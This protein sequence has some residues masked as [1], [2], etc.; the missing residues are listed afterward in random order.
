MIDLFTFIFSIVYSLFYTHFETGDIVKISFALSSVG[1]Q[2]R[3]IDKFD[4]LD[5]LKIDT[6]KHTIQGF[7]VDIMCFNPSA[8]IRQDH[9]ISMKNNNL[10]LFID[11]NDTSSTIANSIVSIQL[12]GFR[13]YKSECV[14][15]N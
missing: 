4:T 5:T 12:G 13:L 7:V 8:F 6:L 15:K 3:F 10:W 1:I 9:G 14:L 11:N 2:S